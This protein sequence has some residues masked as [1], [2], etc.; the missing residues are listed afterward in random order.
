MILFR[1]WIIAYAFNPLIDK[2]IAI[3][4]FGT[5]PLLTDPNSMDF[6]FFSFTAR[7]ANIFSIADAFGCVFF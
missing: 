1:I 4:F 3:P 7:I 6:K 5:T 2:M